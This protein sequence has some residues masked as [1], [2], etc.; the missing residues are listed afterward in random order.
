MKTYPS[1][2]LILPTYTISPYHHHTRI[3]ILRENTSAK[4]L[5]HINSDKDD[6]LWD[7]KTYYTKVVF[8]CVCCFI[9]Y[10]RIVSSCSRGQ[11][12][13]VVV[14]CL[15]AERVWG[16]AHVESRPIPLSSQYSAVYTLSFYLQIYFTIKYTKQY[17][18][19]KG[20]YGFLFLFRFI[21][22]LLYTHTNRLKTYTRR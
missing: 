12:G 5:Q 2:F 18:T 1:A 16:V 4:M 8:V 19:V 17:S 7:S 15:F 3:R 13:T 14:Y 9:G 21:T 10:L 20:R 11:G 6:M 22:T